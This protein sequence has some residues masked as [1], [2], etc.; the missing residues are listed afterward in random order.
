MQLAARILGKRLVDYAHVFS[1]MALD[2][3]SPIFDEGD[4][5]FGDNRYLQLPELG[6]NIVVDA[7]EDRA[8]GLQL[9]SEG[10]EDRYAGFSGELFQNVT[11]SSDRAN[12][13]AVFGEPVRNSAGG[14][15]TG[16]MGADGP[17]WDLFRTHEWDINMT[18]ARNAEAVVF[19]SVAIHDDRIAFLT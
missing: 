18:Y 1:N 9:Y 4:D 6:L 13:R 8:I 11:F 16:L 5:S 17:P 3:Q 12:V 7:F 10:L 14:P 15:G 19:I 2:L